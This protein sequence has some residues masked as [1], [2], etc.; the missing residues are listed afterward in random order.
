MDSMID[1]V[2]SSTEE[3]AKQLLGK[4]LI[5]RIGTKVYSGYI[6][7]T[8]AYVGVADE[9]CHTFGGRRTPKVTSMYQIGGTIYIYTMHTHHMLNIVTKE[10]E[11]PQ[12]V[13]IRAI[14]PAEGIEY[15]ERN[16]NH[17]GVQVSN[18]P[19][20]LTK[21]M[22]ITKALDGQN[23]GNCELF[24]HEAD[25]KTPLEIAESP[26]IGIPNKG[27]WTSALLRYYVKGNPFVSGL[28]KRDWDKRNYGW[29]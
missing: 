7:E 17:T 13:L 10:E 1:F 4:K 21:A 25:K 5:H 2:N 6:T 29:S 19:G 18:G 23:I 28:P 27:I 12:A 8:E 26:R 3:V 15:M 16:R 14:E 20:K 11:D 22:E 24:I 9:A